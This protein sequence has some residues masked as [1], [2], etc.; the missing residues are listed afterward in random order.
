[1]YLRGGARPG[2]TFR[3][4]ILMHAVARLAFHGLIDNIQA[5]WVKMGPEGVAACLHAGVNDLGGSLMNESITRAAGSDHGQE[6][7]PGE[8]EA[9]IRKAQRQ[10]RMRNTLYGDA[11]PGRR[12][13]AMSADP[14]RQVVNELAGKQQRSKRLT[15]PDAPLEHLNWVASSKDA[16]LYEQV[17]LRA[18]FN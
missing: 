11:A 10:P 4:A 5:S 18:A 1:M 17:I 9:Q 7:A 6:W 3:E 15:I 16:S 13:A 14:V 2:P 8:M 12:D